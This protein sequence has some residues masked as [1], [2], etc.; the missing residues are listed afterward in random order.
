ML[1]AVLPNE[2]GWANIISLSW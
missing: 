1:L 2:K